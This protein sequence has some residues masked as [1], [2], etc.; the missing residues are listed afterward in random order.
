MKYVTFAVLWMSL[1][2]VLSVAQE[3]CPACEGAPTPTERKAIQDEDGAP[4]HREVTDLNSIQQLKSAFNGHSKMPRAIVLLS[5]TCPMCIRGAKWFQQEVLENHAEQ[6]RTYVVWLPMLP[7]DVRGKIPRE[8]IDDERVSHFWDGD[9]HAGT[10][11]SK[12]VP[13]CPALGKVAWDAIYLFDKTAVWEET[14]SEP[15]ACATPIFRKTDEL[16]EAFA[17]VLQPASDGPDETRTEKR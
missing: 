7:T 15:A 10:W 8:L 6:F 12:S 4:D 17:E 13:D 3:C 2:P 16:E 1:Y 9:R 5:P 11:F 14:L